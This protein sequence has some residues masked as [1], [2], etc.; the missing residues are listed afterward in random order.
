MEHKLAAARRFATVARRYVDLVT[1]SAGDPSDFARALLQSLAS[2]YAAALE[3]HGELD[4]DEDVEFPAPTFEE[5][6]AIASSIASAFGERQYYWH[7]YDP[8]IPRDGAE[9]LVLG[10]LADDCADIHRDIIGPLEAFE[11]GATV[12]L[13]NILWEWSSIPFT[14]HWGIHAAAAI[15][16]LHWIVFNHGIPE[17]G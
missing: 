10:S 5:S 3:I 1:H 6:R 9:D 4:V 8:I 12:G 17:D 11:S 16:A 13:D 2:L 14:S 7:Q 15:H